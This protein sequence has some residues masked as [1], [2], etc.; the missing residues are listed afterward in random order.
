MK[1]ILVMF[2]IVALI[3]SFLGCNDNDNDNDITTAL[4]VNYEEDAHDL[5]E[6]DYKDFLEKYDES[7]IDT[8]LDKDSM[9][10]LE[11]D[12]YYILKNGVEVSIHNDKV[13][14]VRTFYNIDA[15]SP[16]PV[17][18]NIGGEDSYDDV[19]GKLGEPYYEGTELTESGETGVKEFLTAVFYIGRFQ[20]L[21]VYFDHETEYVSFIAC[22]YG[23]EPV[24]DQT[25]TITISVKLSAPPGQTI[26]VTQQ[27]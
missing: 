25:D 17:M 22:F 26:W 27:M 4:G 15:E 21:K 12:Y 6:I 14:S 7:M 13:V 5:M 16:V 10:G 2:L 18:K 9:D 24:T 23:E 19:V 8:F 11:A 1:K 20:Y 3:F